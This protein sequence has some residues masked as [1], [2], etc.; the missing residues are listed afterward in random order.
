VNKIDLLDDRAELDPLWPYEVLAIPV[1]HCSAATGQGI[2]RLGDALAG[3]LCV[4]AG[5]SGVGKSSLL[6]ALD[7]GLELA[8]NSVRHTTASSAL[9]HLSNGGMVI[10]T[11]GVRE[12]GLWNISAADVRRYYHD[13]A[14][15]LRAFSDCSHINEPDCAVKAAVES[16]AIAAARYE[17]YRRIV[18]SL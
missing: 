5:H 7:Q 8:T 2:E 13:F 14:N 16:G 10:D 3:K 17:S 12:F 9:Y 18:E 15:L 1:V 6:N 11:P 4:F